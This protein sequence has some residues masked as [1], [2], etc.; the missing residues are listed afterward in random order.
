MGGGGFL[1]L[2]IR[3]KKSAAQ[4]IQGVADVQGAAAQ[5]RKGKREVGRSEAKPKKKVFG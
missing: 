2:S 3:W 1:A 4:P 5:T